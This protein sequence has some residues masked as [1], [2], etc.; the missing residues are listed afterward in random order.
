MERYKTLVDTS[1][2]Y[3]A[4]IGDVLTVNMKGYCYC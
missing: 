3:T 4:N 1:Y 2:G